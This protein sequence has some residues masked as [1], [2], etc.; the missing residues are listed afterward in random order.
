MR[1]LSILFLLVFSNSAFAT[2]YQYDVM[3]DTIADQPERQDFMFQL[4]FD[5][6]FG[7]HSKMESMKLFGTKNGGNVLLFSLNAEGI[8]KHLKIL[9]YPNRSFKVISKGAFKTTA[10]EAYSSMYSDAPFEKGNMLEI[11]ELKMSEKE[12]DG[13]PGFQLDNMTYEEMAVSGFLKLNKIIR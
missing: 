13:N 1:I 5:G 4:E 2:I 11:S 8:Q 10:N 3:M 9:W 7:P 6:D 12:S